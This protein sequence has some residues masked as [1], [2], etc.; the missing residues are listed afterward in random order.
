[1]RTMLLNYRDHGRVDW[2]GYADGFARRETRS[3][4]EPYQKSYAEGFEDSQRAD[5]RPVP[6]AAASAAAAGR[7]RQ[8]AV[9]NNDL[10]W[11]R[12]EVRGQ[13]VG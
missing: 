9:G 3:D 4:D 10:I 13:S 1:M 7:V 5:A 6:N 11:R 12:G 2:R 8:R